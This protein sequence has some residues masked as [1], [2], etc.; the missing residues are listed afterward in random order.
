MAVKKTTP[1][2]TE[3][4]ATPVT[5]DQGSTVQTAHV[6]AVDASTATPATDTPIV[7]KRGRGRA[8][9]STNDTLK[10][11]MEMKAALATLVAGNPGALS[12]SDVA[13]KLADDPVFSSLV[14]HNTETGE[15]DSLLTSQHVI[16]QV[17][18]L[19]RPALVR[20]KDAAGKWQISK[21]ADGKP[22]IEAEGLGLVLL[23]PAGKTAGAKPSRAAMLEGLRKMLGNK[24]GEEVAA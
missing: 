22:V 20:V 7:P 24:A 3:A 2:V 16:S 8:K 4:S 5:A 12:A 13:A 6:D 15:T 9:G 17:A 23:K 10:W 11:S 21:D 1:D 19:N 14:V 18:N